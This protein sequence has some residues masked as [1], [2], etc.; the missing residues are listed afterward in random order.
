MNVELGKTSQ[1]IGKKHS[2]LNRIYNFLLPLFANKKATVGMIIFLVFVLA[3]IFEPWIA[4]YDPNAAIFPPSQAPTAEH[5]FGT[6]NTGKDVFSQFIYGARSTI[7]V[8]FG[9]GILTTI[10]GLT[11]GLISGFAGRIVDSIL[12][13]VTNLFLVVPG[14]ALLIVIEAY[15][16]NASPYMNGLI[17]AL[18]GWAWGARVFRSM[19]FSLGSRDYVTAAKLSGE[20]NLR[21]MFTQIA[22]NMVSVIASNIM[23]ASLAAILADSGL[24]FLGLESVSS[25]SWGTMLYWAKGSGALLNGSWWW[26]LP[27]GI[28]IALVGMS[29][30]LMNF[31]VDQ[32]TN[33][34]LRQQIRRKHNG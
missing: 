26:F 34:R 13:F 23:Y 21:V 7:V 20:S 19:T 3:A 6:T 9:A 8:G 4:P 17:I 31:A 16:E 24:A 27:P 22:P 32:I 18:T 14:L 1:P 28:G 12:G 15:L 33:P 2:P 11:I 25:V 30:V 10:I 29:L 5:I